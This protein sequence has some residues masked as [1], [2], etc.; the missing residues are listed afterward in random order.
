MDVRLGT[1]VEGTDGRIGQVTSLVIDPQ[2]GEINSIVVRAEGTSTVDRVVPRSSITAYHA[3]RIAVDVTRRDFFELPA[4]TGTRYVDPDALKVNTTVSVVNEQPGWHYAETH[5]VPSG[6]ASCPR[7]MPVLDADGRRIGKLDWFII[8]SERDH[9]SHIVLSEG[10]LF[11][12]KDV[13]VPV[14]HIAS[15]EG[16]QARLDLTADEV[17]KL[18]AAR[19]HA[20]S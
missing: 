8:D 4:Y 17:D 5:H 16:E 2:T 19:P 1:P 13:A 10:H 9:V 6:M 14:G 12:K 18:P 15:L 20:G 7:D 3:D 11:R